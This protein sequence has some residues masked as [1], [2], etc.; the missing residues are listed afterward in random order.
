MTRT[1]CPE[2]M[3]A[4]YGAC[5][6]YGPGGQCL[7]DNREKHMTRTREE[8]EAEK[9]RK[10]RPDLIPGAARIA[11]GRVLAMGCAKHGRCTWTKAGTEQARGETHIASAERHISSLGDSYDAIDA[12]SGLPH[13]WHAAAQLLIAIDC[14][15]RARG[16]AERTPDALPEGWSVTLYGDGTYVATS[17]SKNRRSL[18]CRTRAEAIA[19]ACAYVA[20]ERARDAPT[21]DALP[22][23]WRVEYN[24]ASREWDVLDPHG[25]VRARCATPCEAVAHAR[26]LVAWARSEVDELAG[27]RS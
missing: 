5:G 8:I 6:H 16:T 27:T 14:A 10:P 11:V 19:Y 1:K 24:D 18:P 12:E 25:R 4:A 23:G 3:C 15:E 2:E 13:L 9:A 20:Q 7:A 26:E 17:V 21:P 22:E